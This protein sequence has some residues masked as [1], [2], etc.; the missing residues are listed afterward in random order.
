MCFVKQLKEKKEE[1]GERQQIPKV[2]VEKGVYEYWKVV[3][4]GEDEQRRETKL[5]GFSYHCND[6][7]E[8]KFD[9]NS[10]VVEHGY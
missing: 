8:Q 2:S 9:R 1:N 3:D 10:S 7:R 6:G 5:L 4:V